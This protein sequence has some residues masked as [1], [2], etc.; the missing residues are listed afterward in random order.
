MPATFHIFKVVASLPGQLVANALYAVR[1]GAGFDLH[2]TTTDG[3]AHKLN[4]A[5]VK[6]FTVKAD[7]EA[8]TPTDPNEIVLYVGS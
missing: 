1:V 7:Y 3:V 2:A 6:T 5:T 8:Y 4:T